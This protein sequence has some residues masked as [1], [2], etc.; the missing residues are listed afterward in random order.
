[1]LTTVLKC[2]S[3]FCSSWAWMLQMEIQWN[4][5]KVSRLLGKHWVANESCTFSITL[6]DNDRSQWHLIIVLPAFF[7]KRNVRWVLSGW[8]SGSASSWVFFWICIGSPKRWIS[9][10]LNTMD[11]LWEIILKRMTI[12]Y[13][14]IWI[15][16]TWVCYDT[17]V[18]YTSKRHIRDAWVLSGWGM[19]GIAL[20]FKQHWVIGE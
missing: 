8:R 19:P 14:S 18:W 15:S 20:A 7:T 3:A 9:L 6:D 17:W 1:M 13:T 4:D 5:T 2:L 11:Q 12:G 10:R 16:N